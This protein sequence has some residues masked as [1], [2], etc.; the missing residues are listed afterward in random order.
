MEIVDGYIEPIIRE[1]LAKKK[2]GAF[3]TKDTGERLNGGET[4][5]DHL[6][7]D[8][9]GEPQSVLVLELMMNASG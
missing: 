8:I 7:R 3:D 1:A 2:A 9:E 5:L 4:L 6:I